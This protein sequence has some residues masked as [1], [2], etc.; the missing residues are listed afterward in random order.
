MSAQR[1]DAIAIAICLLSATIGVYALVR[2]MSP[3]WTAF[4][5][6]CVWSF[7]ADWL[8]NRLWLLGLT[9]GAIKGE[10]KRGRLRLTGLPRVMSVGSNVLMGV[11]RYHS[12]ARLSDPPETTAR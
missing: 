3:A 1:K 8:G 11:N 12:R 9:L 7:T 6:A 5:V 10:A 4:D 2:G